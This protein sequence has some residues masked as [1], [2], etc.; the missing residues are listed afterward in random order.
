MYLWGV[1]STVCNQDIAFL[2]TMFEMPHSELLGHLC[3]KPAG[4]EACTVV[5]ADCEERAGALS[6]CPQCTVCL[7]LYVL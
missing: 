7:L 3:D 1:G 2:V 6:M 4:A 5:K